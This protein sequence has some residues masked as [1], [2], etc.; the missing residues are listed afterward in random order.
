MKLFVTIIIISLSALFFSFSFNHNANNKVSLGKMLFN[1]KLLSKDSSISCASCHNP[2]LAFADT[3][4][5]SIG[6]HGKLT[7]RNTP[8]V[9]NMKNRPYYF[10]DGRAGSLEEQ[11][12]M[13]IMNPDEMGLPIVEAI[14]RL[15]Q[16]PFYKKQFQLIFK[17]EPNK[18]NLAEA[19]AAFE[20]TLETSNSK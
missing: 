10:W 4:P 20:N 2:S 5:F 13:P 8:S 14:S 19:F 1:E 3:L 6:I 12:L 17:S 9:L 7:K 11:S 16:S 18:K 15:N